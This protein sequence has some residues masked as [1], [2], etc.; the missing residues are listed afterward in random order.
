MCQCL[1][2]VVMLD[3]KDTYPS[4]H[5][6]VIVGAERFLDM[7]S[8]VHAQCDRDSRKGKEQQVNRKDLYAA[9]CR[10][11]SHA[12]LQLIEGLTC[13]RFNVGAVCRPGSGS[14]VFRS[15]IH[16]AVRRSRGNVDPTNNHSV[17]SHS[18]SLHGSC[19]IVQDFG[20]RE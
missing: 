10:F 9:S 1:S 18:L 12:E 4:E 14:S 11:Q 13:V 20:C 15:I 19:N 7:S 6:K 3:S 16:C 2:S 5:S 8:A 17:K